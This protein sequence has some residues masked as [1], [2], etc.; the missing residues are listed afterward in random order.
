MRERWIQMKK[1]LFIGACSVMVLIAAAAA[2]QGSSSFETFSNA[3]LK[4]GSK[5]QDVRELQGR[6]QYLGYY[7]GN[8]DGD[9]GWQT[10]RA[11]KDFQYK[12]GMKVDGIA[13][14]QTKAMLQKATPGW[15]PGVNQQAE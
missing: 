8:I 6:L 1:K 3:V 14:E 11:V 2:W 7:H 4:Y 15:H 10:Q 9:F 12:F 13:G 5:G